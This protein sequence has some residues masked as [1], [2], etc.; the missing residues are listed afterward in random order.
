VR[1][2][3][4]D[5]AL[6]H[7]ELFRKDLGAFD[8]DRAPGAPAT[9]RELGGYRALVTAAPVFVVEG[10]VDFRVLIGAVATLLGE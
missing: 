6:R 5:A 1:R 10:R 3:D 8:L 7:L 4:A 9:T 2:R